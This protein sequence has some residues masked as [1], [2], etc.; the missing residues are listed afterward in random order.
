MAAPSST[1]AAAEPKAELVVDANETAAELAR[2][3]R[4]GREIPAR[5]MGSKPELAAARKAFRTW[6]A[7]NATLLTRSFSTSAPAK[8]YSRDANSFA[9]VRG[10]RYPP[11]DEKAFRVRLK[12][13]LER[14]ESLVGQ[15]PLYERAK[16]ATDS[17]APTV[18]QVGSGVFIVHLLAGL[19]QHGHGVSNRWGVGCS[20]STAAMKR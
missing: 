5:P 16:A 20:S 3:V 10:R 11:N 14:L 1:A 13:R 17:A 2:R 4:S 8:E 12:G 6:D 19:L 7:F 15:L 9:V 18:E